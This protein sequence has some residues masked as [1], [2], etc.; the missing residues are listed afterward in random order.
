MVGDVVDAAVLLR[1]RVHP[2]AEHRVARHRELAVRVLRKVAAGLPFHDLLVSLDDFAKR[3][4]VEIGVEL[5]AARLLDRVQLVL[6]GLLRDLEHDVA[7]HLDEAAVAVVREAAVARARLQAFDGLVVQPEVEDRVHHPGHG[8]LRAGADGN[9]QGVLR[10]P[11]HGTC[12]LLELLHVLGDL[13]VDGGGDL[14]VLFVV[15][16]ADF[17]RDGEAR[18]HRQSRVGHLGEAGAFAAEKILHVAVAVGLAVAEEVHMFSGFGIPRSGFGRF[19]GFGSRTGLRLLRHC[20][21]SGSK[22]LASSLYR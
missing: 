18:W 16:V 5:L 6:E 21:C 12:G 15:D 8:K 22:R 2:R 10:R 4:L 7:E 13:F 17:G 20:K 1:A 9:E 11:K 14:P 3:L 19:D